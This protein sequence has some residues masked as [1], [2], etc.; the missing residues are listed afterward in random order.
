MAESRP[1]RRALL[2][3]TGLV[4]MV[5]AIWW[6][7]DARE[8][9]GAGREVRARRGQPIQAIEVRSVP[10]S[11]TLDP[12][13]LERDPVGSL[14]LRGIVVDAAGRPVA[15]ASVSLRALAPRTTMTDTTGAWQLEGLL[16]RPY[17][18]EARKE[19][20]WARANDVMPTADRGPIVLRL[21]AGSGLTV[22][23]IDRATGA[24]LADTA[25]ELRDVA[26]MSAV[27]D[28]E[29]L[30]R[31][32]GLP[33]SGAFVLDVRKPGW[34]T[35]RRLVSTGSPEQPVATVRVELDPAAALEGT[36]VDEAGEPVAD[37]VVQA[38]GVAGV[39]ADVVRDGVRTDARGRFAITDA[40][41]TDVR[42]TAHHP[43]FLPGASPITGRGADD[44]EV[45]LRP[46]GVV[47]GRVIGSDG[48]PVP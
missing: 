25:V 46:A 35:E 30:V 23:V 28:R 7:R 32:R 5:A 1:S 15:G 22:Q 37:A 16:P 39:A 19:D 27:T 29:G 11:R 45:Q 38:V 3:A 43:H 4:A 8:P 47:T 26:R 42:V 17:Q 36:V 13:Q 41:P 21:R 48:A 10:L 9:S 34:A 20:D 24:P 6:L 31:L 12:W 18:L 14:A 44:L 2:W 40:N 33:T